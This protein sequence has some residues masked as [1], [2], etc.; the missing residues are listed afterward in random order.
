LQEE[1]LGTT[2]GG[3]EGGE[4]KIQKGWCEWLKLG[5]PALS[6]PLN[7]ADKGSQFDHRKGAS[8]TVT[9]KQGSYEGMKE[10]EKFLRRVPCHLEK[11]HGNPAN[12]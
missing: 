7:V 1:C 4:K 3:R 2:T 5:G 8:V 6:R 12:K 11:Q 10:M 9:S